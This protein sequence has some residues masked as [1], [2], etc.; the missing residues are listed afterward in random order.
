MHLKSVGTLFMVLAVPSVTVLSLDA[1]QRRAPAPHRDAAA[2]LMAQGYSLAPVI[3]EVSQSAPD[4]I[5]VS[6]I[7]QPDGRVR[8]QYAQS[9]AIVATADTRGR[10]VAEL[11]A[12]PHGSV[13]DLSMEN[14]GLLIHAEGR[15]FVPPSAP[16]KAVVLRPG[17]PSLPLVSQSGGLAIIDYDAAGALSV[18]GRV[19][20]RSVVNV[21]VDGEIRAQ[22]T[23][24]ANGMFTAVTQIPPPAEVPATVN[25]S[26]EAAGASWKRTIDVS[27]APAGAI[28]AV[29][30]IPEGWRV[31]WHLPGGGNQTTL[32][33]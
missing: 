5:V 2:E 4:R 21:I 10:F 18:T 11:P 7:A 16:G 26:A 23:S 3:T 27:A 13:F 22:P 8:F 29:T 14:A 12:G 24:D 33:F 9:G 28:D 17:A 32:V 20:P 6:G 25:I 19:A 30:V 1:C 31:D 15:L